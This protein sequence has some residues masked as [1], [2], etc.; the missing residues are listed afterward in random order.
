MAFKWVSNRHA[1]S[2]KRTTSIA[3]LPPEVVSLVLQQF[4]NRTPDGRRGLAKC[5]LVSK[6]WQSEAEP[7]LY[8]NLKVN[9]KRLE[10]FLLVLLGRS[11]GRKRGR[12]EAQARARTRLRWVKRLELYDPITAPGLKS[13]LTLLWEALTTEVSDGSCLFPN[14]HQLK[15][16]SPSIPDPKLTFT[17]KYLKKSSVRPYDSELEPP[18]NRF[19]FD[20]VDICVTG[21]PACTLPESLP[22]R[23]CHSFTAHDIRPTHINNGAQYIIMEEWLENY[24]YCPPAWSGWGQQI[25]GH[26]MLYFNASSVED[27]SKGDGRLTFHAGPLHL[28]MNDERVTPSDSSGPST[29]LEKHSTPIEECKVHCRRRDQ[30]P[31][32]CSSCRE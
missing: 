10:A 20:S 11:Q 13:A 21:F 18:P 19:V 17:E 1:A 30:T 9:P 16:S 7:L 6:K 23:H 14:A 3:S 24:C 8:S 4:D 5:A 27:I 25:F 12:P 29:A 2:S 31:A 26:P 28:A 15:V 32:T 22:M